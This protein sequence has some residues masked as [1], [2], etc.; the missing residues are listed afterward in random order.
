MTGPARAQDFTTWL[1]AEGSTS[2][3]LGFEKEL[4]LA[5][6]NAQDVQVTIA[7]F[8]Q[9]G[10]PI[11][12]FVLTL[13]PL[14]RTGVNV[15]SLPGV[16]DRAGIALRVTATGPIIAERTMYWGGGLFRGGR[17]WASPVSDMRGGHNEKGVEAG[18][19][20]WYFAEGEGKF[21]NTFISVANPNAVPTRV[22]VRYLDDRGAAV[23][24][25]QVIAANA[26]FTF[27]PTA[28]LSPRFQP[29]QAGFAT[30]VEA[31][32]DANVGPKQVIVAERQMYWG[33]G[34]PFGIRGGHA[35]MG[36]TQPS[37]TWMFAEGIQ[38]ST[39]NFDTYLLLFNQNATPTTVTVKFYA[40]G[41]T[42]LATVTRTIPALARDNVPT[43]TVPA[44]AGQAFAMEVTATQPIVA[45]RAVYWRGLLEGHATAG[46]TAP[47]RKWGFA[48]G[49]QGGFLMYQDASQTD[50][51]RFN[52]FF[53]IYNPGASAATVTAYFY[54]EGA[55]TGV[56]KTITVPARSRATIWPLL[57]PELANRKFATFFSSDQAIVAERVVYWGNGFTAGHASL[58]TPLP[59]GF[60]LT[61]PSLPPAAPGTTLTVT[62]GRGVPTGGTT[63]EIEGT[64]F[65]HNDVGTRVLFGGVPATSFEVE[66]DT[67]IRAVTPPGAQGKVDVTVET[68]G[69]TIVAPQAFEYFNPWA[70]TGTPYNTFRANAGFGCTG[71]GRPCQI[72]PSFLNVVSDMA[73]RQ[74][75]DIANSCRAFG[76]NEKFMEDVVAELRIRTG[77]NRWAL[78][79]KRGNQGL[80]EDIVTYYYGPEGSDMRNSTQVFI[81]DIIANHCNPAN[82]SGGAPFWLDQTQATFDGGTIG[83]WTLGEMCKSPRYRDAVNPNTGA[84]LFPECR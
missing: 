44:L 74:P 83:R 18:S 29:G 22:R 23:T 78:N 82:R 16:G 80:S 24:Q 58:G 47:A 1:F 76:G 59:D 14:S 26:R 7:A 5:N 51:R 69:Q 12:P 30:I 42:E 32:D 52:T 35:A 50:K 33:P 6:P 19:Y 43:S 28:V 72:M 68:R 73:R 38:G 17:L 62:P 4:L 81:V 3:L 41:G 40:D 71:G 15:R 13:P 10:D 11:A 55:N 36:V 34:A 48:E 8:T 66:T 45:E 31:I 56:T 49:L 54:T 27:W 2:G 67:L 70:A 9:D 75:F 79:I 25:E 64:G 53:P 37:A 63:V 39:L 77:T 20:T 57:Y 61:A 84:F 21:F 46:A 60:A 65:G